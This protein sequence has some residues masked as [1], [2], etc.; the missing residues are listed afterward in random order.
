MLV[1]KSFNEGSRRFL[2]QKCILLRRVNEIKKLRGKEV[3]S[4][5]VREHAVAHRRAFIHNV[6]HKSST[7]SYGIS[8]FPEVIEK[9]HFQQ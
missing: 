3:T 7:V 6:V 5:K 4:Q 9:F 2:I 1:K 8:L